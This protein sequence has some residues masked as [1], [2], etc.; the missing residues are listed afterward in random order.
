MSP[1][2]APRE[3]TAMQHDFKGKLVTV[4]YDDEVCVHAAQCV[5]S[6]RAVFDPDRTP[7]VD[8]DGASIEAIRRAV[9]ACPSGALE[10]RA[11]A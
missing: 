1:S 2:R 7:W 8:P 5:G 6:L 11:D 4:S 3:I 10:V 9:D